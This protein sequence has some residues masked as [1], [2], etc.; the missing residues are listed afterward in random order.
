VRTNLDIGGKRER[1]VER[2]VP[3]DPERR[4]PT[5]IPVQGQLPLEMVLEPGAAD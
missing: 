2:A 3:A 1:F 5:G 4:H